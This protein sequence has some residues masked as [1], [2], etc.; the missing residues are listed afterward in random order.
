M[1]VFSLENEEAPDKVN[2]A[3]VDHDHLSVISGTKIR[4][5]III[6]IFFRVVWTLLVVRVGDL[7]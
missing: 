6:I 2:K 1:R 3:I 4:A 5:I 7:Q